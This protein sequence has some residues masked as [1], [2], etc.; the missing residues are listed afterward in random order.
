MS[1]QVCHA[2]PL[3][4]VVIEHGSDEVLE[5][6]REVSFGLTLPVD[7]PELLGVMLGN[8][9]VKWIIFLGSLMEGVRS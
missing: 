3:L 7:L 5:L 2:K 8:M 6:L 1:D 4:W 9:L